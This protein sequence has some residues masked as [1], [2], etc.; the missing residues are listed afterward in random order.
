MKKS[1][2]N[3]DNSKDTDK[4]S[5]QDLVVQISRLSMAMVLCVRAFYYQGNVNECRMT[6]VKN[7]IKES[8]YGK[9]KK[10]T[11]NILTTFFIS[12]KSDVKTFLK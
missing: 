4:S 2:E 8:F 5:S 12:H 11:I 10:K 9:R 7:L 1:E 6:L 3:E